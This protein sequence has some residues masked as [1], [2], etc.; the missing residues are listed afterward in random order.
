MTEATVTQPTLRIRRATSADN[1]LLA[2]I[3]AETFRDTF[4]AD[5]TPE[6]MAAYLAGAFNPDRQA[7]E[8]AEPDS[9]FLIAELGADVVGYTRLKTAPPP[10]AIGAERALEIARLYARKGWI[11]QGVGA[12]LMRA[13]LATAV[14]DGYPVV[15]LD[16]WEKN[17]RAIAFYEKWGFKIVGEQTFQLG[18]DLQHDWLMSRSLGETR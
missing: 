9:M 6:D 17:P 2:Q 1:A 16:V 11:G 4:E 12:A 8:L 5:N 15:W 14:R 13:C 18:A 3:G 7:Q 10:A